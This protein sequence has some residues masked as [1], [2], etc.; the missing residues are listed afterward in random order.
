MEANAVI[1]PNTCQSQEYWHLIKGADKI[2]WEKSFV[3]ELSRLAQGV[4]HRLKGTNIIYF[5][6]NTKTHK[7]TYGKIVCNVK[8]QKVETHRTRLTVGGN[9]LYFPGTL[10]IPTATV[11]TEKNVQQC[12]TNKKFKMCYSRH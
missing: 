11:A 3:N 8:P 9:L 4:G 5:T 10:T 12:C 7:I 1:H 2:I 6:P